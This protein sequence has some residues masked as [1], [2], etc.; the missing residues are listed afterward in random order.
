MKEQLEKKAQVYFV[1]YSHKK[2]RGNGEMWFDY[3]DHINN[4]QDIRELERAIAIQLNFD[5]VTVEHYT[6]LRLAV[7][8]DEPKIFF[9]S[10]QVVPKP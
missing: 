4:I 6:P 1:T 7:R 8:N 5:S 10:G 9:G 3:K 2:G